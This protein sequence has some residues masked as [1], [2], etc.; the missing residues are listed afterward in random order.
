MFLAAIV[1]GVSPNAA[2][3]ADFVYWG[4][5]TYSQ[6]FGAGRLLTDAVSTEMGRFTESA[7]GG[8]ALSYADDA[9]IKTHAFKDVARKAEPVEDGR[10]WAEAL[11]GV[12]DMK[13]RSATGAP[14]EHATN[15]GVAAGVDTAIDANLRIGFAMSGGQSALKVSALA[16]RSDATW[17]LA[18]FYGVATDGATYA[19]TSLTIGYIT[20]ET[21][22][23]V[24]VST[25][26]QKA[27]G[28]YDSLLYAARVEVGQRLDTK[29]VGMTPFVAFEPS[30]VAQNGYSEK[31]SAPIALSFD[32]STANA[33]PGTLG[34][35]VDGDIKLRNIRLTPSATVGWVH[36]FAKATSIT[37]FFTSLPGSTFTVA[38]AEGDRDLARMEF[39]IEASRHGSMASVFANTRADFG[40][41]TSSVRGAGGVMMRF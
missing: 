30:L 31:A 16:T 22:R 3:A 36:N 17:G 11:G 19:K 20:A 32:K 23:T 35:K 5:S 25:T 9:R 24:I 4:D 41:R 38:R 2:L 33:L 28:T 34:L 8:E 1:L 6:A 39:N 10:V 14:A 7:G 37:P 13:A 15:Y 18:A 12:A 40:Q 26:P 29:R 21:E 27:T